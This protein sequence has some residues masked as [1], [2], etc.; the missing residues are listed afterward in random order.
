M[1]GAEADVYIEHHGS[2]WLV[3]PQTGRA[4]HW[5]AVSVDPEATWMGD[6]LVVEHRYVEDVVE[7]MTADG[8]VVEET[9]TTACPVVETWEDLFKVVEA[10]PF[11]GLDP[12]HS[13]HVWDPGGEHALCGSRANPHPECGRV[14]MYE[15]GYFT[16]YPPVGD[17]P[18]RYCPQCGRPTCEWCLYMLGSA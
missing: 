9:W 18:W 6:A 17:P 14:G 5:I 3:S 10:D 7:G 8:L 4:L 13:V 1:N 16:G 2:V 11:A 15:D 12:E